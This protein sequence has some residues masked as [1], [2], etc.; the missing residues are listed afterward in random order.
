MLRICIFGAGGRMGRAVAA[1]ALTSYADRIRVVSA[2]ERPNAPEVGKTVPGTDVLILSS[3]GL[4]E[5]LKVG[6][7]CVVSFSA[8]NAD[9]AYAPRIAAKGI[10]LVIGTTGFS[11]EQLRA[12][13]EGIKRS[14]ASAVISPNF[15]PLVNAQFYLTRTAAKILAP[16]GYDYGIIEEHHIMKKDAPSGTAKKLAREI[17]GVGAAKEVVYRGEGLREKVR[18]ELDMAVLRLGGT[19]GEHEVRIV[20]QHGRLTI[21]T[22]MY[23]RSD[24]ARGALEAALWLEKNREPGRVFSMED[25]MGLK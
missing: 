11:E 18:G 4:E 20:G 1:E 14:R 16:Y 7:D 3:E 24:F 9:A 19:A 17:I 23:N 5:A 21:G 13:H 22:L 15:S 8:P 2:I 25:V 6:V 10:D 12:I